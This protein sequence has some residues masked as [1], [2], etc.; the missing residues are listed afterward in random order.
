MALW[1]EGAPAV[2]EVPSQLELV[3]DTLLAGLRRT[4]GVDAL[5]WLDL[6]PETLGAWTGR[7]TVADGRLF[8]GR[9][10]FPFLDVFLRDA[11]A[12]LDGRPEFR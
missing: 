3:K 1:L 4:M 11:F 10:A 5:P 7:V 6:L 9:E 12:E 8:L 2:V